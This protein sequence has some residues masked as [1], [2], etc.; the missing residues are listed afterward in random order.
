MASACSG[1][2]ISPQAIVG[3]PTAALIAWASGTW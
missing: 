1:S 2:V 3:K